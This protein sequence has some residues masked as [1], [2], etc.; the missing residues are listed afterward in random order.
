MIY[1]A[2]YWKIPLFSPRSTQNTD[3]SEERKI[4]LG[5][6]STWG[7]FLLVSLGHGSLNSC[8]GHR[9]HELRQVAFLEVEGQKHGRDSRGAHG[10]SPP[11]IQKKLPVYCLE[12]GRAE[13]SCPNGMLFIHLF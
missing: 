7:F 3:V 12:T 5:E 9:P 6:L 13:Q 2:F 1:V 8:G 4:H 10:G 11:P